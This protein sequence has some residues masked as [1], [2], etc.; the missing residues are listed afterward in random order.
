MMTEEA[1]KTLQKDYEDV[2][3]MVVEHQTDGSWL[4]NFLGFESFETKKYVIDDFELESA[5]NYDDIYLKNSIC[6]FEHLKD[7]PKYILSNN[8]FWAWLTFEKAY[9]Q[10]I[11][12][13]P[14]K[15]SA[16]IKN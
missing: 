1:Y 8:R 2:Y 12:S 13:L 7:L 11:A 6:L 16:I 9:R 3:K 14:V 4:K 10:A 15:S 5:E